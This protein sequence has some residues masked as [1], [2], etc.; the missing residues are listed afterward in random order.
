MV[1]V[2]VR[3]SLGRSSIGKS[4]HGMVAFEV[5]LVLYAIPRAHEGSRQQDAG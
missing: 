4:R 5:L 3:I 2:S 1:I